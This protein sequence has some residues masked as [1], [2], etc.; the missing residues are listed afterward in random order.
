MSERTFTKY[1]LEVWNTLGLDS[2]A[3]RA[4]QNSTSVEKG[5]VKLTYPRFLT[6]LAFH[7]FIKERVKIAIVET[8]LGGRYDSTNIITNPVVVGLTSVSFDHKILGNTIE[9]IARHKAG[10]MK[11]GVP[12]FT[13]KQPDE[14]WTIFKREA[15]EKNVTLQC[16]DGEELRS[17]D[18]NL[19][20]ECLGVNAA[21]AVKLA[22]NIA[23]KMG[24]PLQKSHIKAV[25]TTSHRG[26]FTIVD[27]DH[28]TWFLDGAH[29]KEA[30]KKATAWFKRQ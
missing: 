28:Q 10:I 13:V 25:M 7:I 24:Y 21:L 19:P 23:N 5:K 1:F 9:D 29:N 2:L 4:D 3:E 8:G 20:D 14:V 17:L 15:R 11:F 12:A 18:C 6:L 27:H 16:I 26:R 30:I 22:N